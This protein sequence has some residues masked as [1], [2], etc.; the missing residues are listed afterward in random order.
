MAQHNGFREAYTIVIDAHSERASSGD[1]PASFQ[2]IP[3][4]DSLLVFNASAAVAHVAFD[5]EAAVHHFPIP[6]GG[7]RLLDM[8]PMALSAS[9]ILDSGNGTVYLS[10]GNGVSY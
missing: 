3:A 2:D 1:L 4:G 7:S 8:G 10:R 9:V 6:P 5:K